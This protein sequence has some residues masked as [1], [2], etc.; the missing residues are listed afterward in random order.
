MDFGYEDEVA[1][2]VTI[3]AAPSV[4]P[5]P[6][7]LDAQVTWL[8][9]AEVCIPGKAH[10][11][12]DLT[13]QPGAPSV[14]QEPTLGALGEAMTL[15]PRPLP[16]GAKFTAAAD[17]QQFV[18]TLI[19]G[20][21]ADD[22]EFYPL[23]SDP[24]AKDAPDLIVNSADQDIDTQPD[25]V[26]LTIPRSPD[27][28]ALPA[29]IHGIFK[30]SD[31]VAYEVSA[32]VAPAASPTPTS[33]ATASGITTLGAIGLAF[34]GGI[35]LNLMPCVFPVLFLKGLG[36]VQKSGHEREHQQ[37]HGLVYT[38]GI[39]VSFWAIVAALLLLRA[40]GSHIGWGFQLQ[41]PAFIA[42]LASFM[43][44]FALSLAGQFDIGL[45]LTSVGE[46]LAE[47]QGYAG[48]FFTGVLATVVAT[49][50]TAPFMG[51]AVGFALA[52]TA[53]VTFAVFTAL[54]L[55]LA[56]PYLALSWHPA[57]VSLLPKPGAWMELLKQFTA[58]PLFA[59]AI[60]L[61]W[62]YGQLY[63]QL[64]APSEGV[65]HVA[66]LLACFLLL[67]IAGWALG[68]WPAQWPSRIAALVLIALALAIPLSQ[69]HYSNGHRTTD[70]EQPALT[71]AQ[72]ASSP[73]WQPYSES[74]LTSARAA[75][76]P[77]LIDFTAAWCLSCQ[78]NERRVLKSADVEAALEKGSVVTMKADW[79][80]SDPAITAKLASIGRAGVPTYVLY[81]AAP[82]APADVLPELLTK[83]LVLKAIARDTQ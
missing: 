1:F 43:F 20:K 16:P 60:W 49:P 38:L 34:L 69:S 67:A 62:V 12:L 72:P 68:R 48:S 29:T 70:N 81:P 61:A 64:S 9:C 28:A 77:V 3:A 40:G 23:N 51:A 76:H 17:S 56:A 30:L 24:S 57:W 2:P 58:V 75:G 65:N 36:L 14:A 37:R 63:G 13:A 25:G 33:S 80:N 27:L 59:T 26:R 32:P 82:A 83:D 18:L 50:C 15:I 44:F 55:G 71:I 79:T 46:S 41:S 78:F 52:Q 35:I 10:L 6:L 74:A 11:G 22:A 21:S 73:D 45:S 39:L 4:T 54:A 7:H 5:G 53:A 42:V 8:V 19:D 47:K 66:L 31:T